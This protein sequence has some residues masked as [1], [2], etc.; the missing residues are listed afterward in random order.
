MTTCARPDCGHPAET[1]KGDGPCLHMEP[2]DAGMTWCCPCS[3]FMTLEQLAEHLERLRTPP[4][5]MDP[6]VAAARTAQ[7]I[8]ERGGGPGMSVVRLLTA[9]HLRDEAVAK[10]AEPPVGQWTAAT[11]PLAK[12]CPGS[13]IAG[14]VGEHTACPVCS[15]T[16]CIR[17]DG[18]LL[19]H[20]R[21]GR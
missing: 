14:Y 7:W 10:A 15:G 20:D 16:V 11:E 18:V 1:H 2:R 8:V 19:R 5:P 6:M 21:P 4:P 3:S 9:Q 13:G 12:T 17:H